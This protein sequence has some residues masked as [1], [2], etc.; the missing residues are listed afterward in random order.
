MHEL[1]IR[2]VF[3]HHESR[4]TNRLLHIRSDKRAVDPRFYI[5]VSSLALLVFDDGLKQIRAAKVWPQ[6][7]CYV[8]LTI[9]N[10]PEQ[11]IRYSHFA[12]RSHQQIR[13]GQVFGK[14][15]PL[16]I[17]FVDLRRIAANTYTLR[18]YFA[19][20]FNYLGS[21]AVVQRYRQYHAGV[22]AGLAFGSVDFAAYDALEFLVATYC[23]K[24]NV[25][26]FEA[27]DFFAQ[28]LPQQSHERLNFK[29]RALPVFSRECVK[30]KI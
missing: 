5:A 2:P 17:D 7:I 21:T 29:P 26:G 16:Y 27:S 18:D 15:M 19:A 30:R 28:E 14:K 23:L 9:S 10:L 22:L 25:V 4:V 8:D 1:Y 6:H 3:R 20:S 24:P 12:A 13:V 11:E